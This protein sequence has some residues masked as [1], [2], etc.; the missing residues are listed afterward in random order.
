MVVN[1]EPLEQVGTWL[2]NLSVREMSHR[3][4]LQVQIWFPSCLIGRK[5]QLNHHQDSLLSLPEV[6]LSL[7]LT[8]EVL[9]RSWE[10]YV[11]LIVGEGSCLCLPSPS[12]LSI[13]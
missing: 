11:K 1:T 2:Q 7:S 8:P 3:I 4:I 6:T 10:S 13:A 12:L 5:S 9:Q